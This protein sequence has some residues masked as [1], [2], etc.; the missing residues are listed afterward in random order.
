MNDCSYLK[1][2]D[3]IEFIVG[4]IILVM[5]AIYVATYLTPARAWTEYV[6]VIPA[7]TEFTQ[8]EPI[9]FYSVT[10]GKRVA[11]TIWTNVIRCDFG[12]GAQLVSSAASASGQWKG[13]QSE[14][15]INEAKKHLGDTDALRSYVLQYG[16]KPWAYQGTHPARSGLCHAEHSITQIVGMFKIEKNQQIIG[17]T[18]RYTVR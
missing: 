3:A 11:D 15:F 7:K 13:N 12:T 14:R 8:G 10:H 9:E 5:A 2:H 6:A 4:L 1:I 17:P 16:D 18:F